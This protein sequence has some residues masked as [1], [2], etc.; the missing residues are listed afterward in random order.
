MNMYKRI[1]DHVARR[2][3]TIAGKRELK[4]YLLGLYEI[5]PSE[6]DGYLCDNEVECERCPT[7]DQD[8][9]DDEY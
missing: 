6:V 2:P 7:P 5:D 9:E 8:D 3:M 1:C 4:Q